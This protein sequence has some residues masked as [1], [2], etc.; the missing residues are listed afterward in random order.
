MKVEFNLPDS[1][2]AHAVTRYAVENVV[3]FA[4]AHYDLGRN[5]Y[6]VEVD[7]TELQYERIYGFVEGI[8]S[9]Q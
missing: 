5:E 7:C 4:E 1:R 2:T 9:L 6:I 3:D 8:L